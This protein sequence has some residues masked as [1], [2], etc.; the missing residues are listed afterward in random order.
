MPAEINTVNKDKLIEDLQRRLSALEQIVDALLH[1]NEKIKQE[2]RK[3]KEE[4]ETLQERVKELEAKCNSNSSN[5]SRPPS[6]DGLKKAPAFGRKAE[7]NKGGKPGHKGSTLKQ[8]EQPDEI[9]SCEPLQCSCGHQFDK[10]ELEIAERRQLFDIPQPKLIVTE[11]QIMKGRCPQCGQIHKGKAPQHVK[12][13]T[14]YGEGVKAYL[15]MLN[16]YFNV[17]FK[18]IQTLFNDIYGYPINESTIFSA[19][20]KIYK[21]LELTEKIIAERLTNSMVN[22]SDESGARINGRLQ[23]LHVL[24]NPENTLLFVHPKRGLKAMLSEKSPLKNFSGWLVHDSY[25]SYFKFNQINHSLCGAHILRELQGVIDYEKSKWAVVFKKF[26]M[27]IYEMDIEKRKKHKE[28]ILARYMKI[29][30]IGEK[31]EPPPKKTKGR[32]KRTKGRNLVERLIRDRDMVLAFAFNRGIPFTNNLAER[33]VRPLK[34]KLKVAG[35]FR[36]FKGAEIYA[37]IQAFISTARKNNKNVFQEIIS[38]FHGNNF[39]TVEAGK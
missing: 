25:H 7:G 36:T 34:T 3:L 29:C 2:N 16:N 38:T 5:S 37:R 10:S 26:L 17:P 12:A 24:S 39:L 14:Q 31:S 1:E 15:I 6:S 27:N 4:N 32:Q 30:T 19:N 23:W 13:P 22:H 21:E 28:D 18:K 33:D 8:V 9:V 11:Y 20:E 35:S